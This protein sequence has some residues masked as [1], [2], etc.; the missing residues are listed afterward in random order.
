MNDSEI[1]AKYGIGKKHAT[2]LAIQM[3]FVILGT[4]M[5]IALIIRQFQTSVDTLNLL[6]N[7]ITLIAYL[8]I[9]IYAC[10][11]FKKQG[12]L[13]FNIA[14]YSYA[15][16]FGFQILM[17]GNMIGASTLSTGLAIFINICNLIAFANVIK[18]ADKQ[19]EK[20]K[21]IAYL[22][23]AIVLKLVG[24][25]VLN[26]A[27]GGGF[28]LLYVLMSLANPILGM[29]LLSAYLARLIKSGK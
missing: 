8:A 13:Y 9:I 12:K 28:Q 17:F 27:Y 5:T 1:Q 10:F 23:F 7:I 25:I 18:F 16:V 14:V 19:D 24:E 3:L 21:A 11:N 2:F 29:T 20:K 15:A 22:V 26:V 4:I 6:T